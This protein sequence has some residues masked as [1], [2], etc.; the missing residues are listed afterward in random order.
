MENQVTK[1]L[2]KYPH[3]KDENASVIEILVEAEINSYKSTG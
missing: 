1:L 2:E 3:L